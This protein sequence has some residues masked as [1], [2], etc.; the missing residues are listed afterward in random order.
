MANGQRTAT[1]RLTTKVPNY[2]RNIFPGGTFFLTVVT[3]RRRPWLVLEAARLA[4]RQAIR[5]TR[6]KH[7]FEIDAIVLLPDHFH[8]IWTLPIGD[9]RFSLRMRLI[10]TS[11]SKNFELPTSMAGEMTVSRHKRKESIHW[12]RRFWEHTIRDNDDFRRHC[13]YIHYNPV[14][15]GYCAAPKDWRFSSFHRYVRLDVYDIDWGASEEPVVP[16]FIVG[17]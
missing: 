11:V 14:K 16:E 17:E 12:Q 6:Q 3:Y 1:T 2:R 15:H 13:D 4:L 8:C 10:K 5:T 9:S 7:P